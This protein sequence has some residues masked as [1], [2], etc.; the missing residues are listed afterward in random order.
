MNHD[1]DMRLRMTPSP[2][3]RKAAR[4]LLDLG[5]G[6]VCVPIALPGKRR[7]VWL[8]GQ[9][10]EH[11]LAMFATMSGDDDTYRWARN[12]A[13]RVAGEWL[14]QHNL[15]GVSAW[16]VMF[17]ITPLGPDDDGLRVAVFEGIYGPKDDQP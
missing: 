11:P 10:V 16:C 5:Y 14:R 6:S 9:R 4:A 15:T 1:D 8:T 12:E 7:G 3:Q 13:D 2:E 17:A